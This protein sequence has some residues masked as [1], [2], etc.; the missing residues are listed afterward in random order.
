MLFRRDTALC[1]IPGH[2]APGQ[3]TTAPT[4]FG[5][6][7][8]Q[9]EDWRDT[10][11]AF[12]FRMCVQRPGWPN[13]ELGIQVDTVSVPVGK[14]PASATDAVNADAIMTLDF[15]KKQRYYRIT[16]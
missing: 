2:L 12:R 13:A 16:R 5:A 14:R 11:T 7:D 6:L 9:K 3:A 4:S 8:S 15:K 10:T 1:P